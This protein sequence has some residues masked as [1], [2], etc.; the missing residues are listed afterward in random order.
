MLERALPLF[1]A[2]GDEQEV[3]RTLLTLG[4]VAREQGDAARTVQYCQESLRRCRELGDSI[5]AAWSLH[6]LGLAAWMR[7]DLE[8]A[9]NLSTEAVRLLQEAG[10]EEG[11]AEPLTALALVLRDQGDLPGADHVLGKVLRFC[12][13]KTAY[14]PVAPMALEGTAGVAATRGQHHRG[15]R[16]YAAAS[17]LRHR[18]G[19]P[20]WPVHRRRHEADLALVRGALGPEQFSRAWEEGQAMTLERSIEYALEPTGRDR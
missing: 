10:W 19:L 17:S 12:M 8:R 20:S 2:L 1:Q 4:D 11:I 3:A 15:T 6:S 7:G 13:S 14:M 16:L 9:K 5:G 18:M